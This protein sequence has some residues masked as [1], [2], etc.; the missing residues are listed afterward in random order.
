MAQYIDKAA[1][2]AEIERLDE[3][4]HFYKGAA[5]GQAFVQSLLSFIDTL[6]VKEV[7][8]NKEIS[9]FIDANFEKATIG[10]KLS[11]KRVAKYFFELGVQVNNPITAADKG[12][13]EEIIINLKR[14]EQ[15]YHLDLTKE[16]EWVRNKIQKGE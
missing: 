16:M 9:Q 12:M 15:D 7:D 14:V 10:Y 11:L 1:V 13:A 2:V 3:F 6:D 8:I 5:G 4:W